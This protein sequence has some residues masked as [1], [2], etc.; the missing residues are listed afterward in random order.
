MVGNLKVGDQIP[1]THNR[2][3]NVAD[4]ESFNNSID[5]DYDSEDAI[6]NGYI[7]KMNT[8]QFNRVVRSDYG[9]GCD[10]KHEFIKN[11]GNDCFVTTKV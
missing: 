4:Y 8:P 3:S 10:F 1:Q 6:F 7:Y 9:I 11:R 5:Q 2:F